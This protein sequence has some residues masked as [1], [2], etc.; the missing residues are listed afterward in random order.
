MRAATARKKEEEKAKG[1][2]GA[3]SSALMAVGKGAPKREADGKDNHPSKK[4]IVTPGDKLPK[5]PLPPKP[6]HGVGKRLMT[7]SGPVSQG[8]DHRLLSHKDYAVEMIESI[9]KD[10]DVDLCAEQMMKELRLSS[11]FY[12]ARVRLFLFSFSFLFIHYLIANDF[13]ICRYQST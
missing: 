3:S 12:L 2:D 6:S 1:K 10:K 5:K 7:T 13:S 9:I 11:L 4:V 8:P